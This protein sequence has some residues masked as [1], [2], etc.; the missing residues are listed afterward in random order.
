MRA[1][2]RSR[3]WAGLDVGSYSVKMLAVLGGIGSRYWIG[4]APIVSNGDGDPSAESV[5]RSISECLSSAGL[6]PRSFRGVTVGISGSDVIVKQISL[7]LLDDSEVG[8]ALRFEARKHL[9]F[10]PQTMILDYQVIGRWATERKLDVLLAAVSIDHVE[11]HLAPLRLLG[12]E[13]DILD[14]APLALINAVAYGSELSGDAHVL[15]DVGH[16]ASHLTLYQKGQ[17]YFARRLD[18]GGRSLTRAIAEGTRV[19]F[20]EAD[21]WK[22][23]AGSDEPGFRV[24]W[25][26]MEL[27]SATES[28]RNDLVEELRRS[29]VFYRTQGRLPDP[30]PLKVSGGSMRLPGLAA[31]LAEL[32]GTPVTLFNPLASFNGP[33][34]GGVL[35]SAAPQFAQAFGLITRTT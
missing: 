25:N 35:P 9:P 3:P 21:E 10:D 8:P 27:V 32:I 11:K 16:S 28:L 33:P 20:E 31:K 19:P 6:S 30:L 5:A 15:L 7:P 23:A 29:F 18:F 14:A 4:E 2:I 1:G 34:R 24:D 22:L 17:P 13:A 26:S 12:M